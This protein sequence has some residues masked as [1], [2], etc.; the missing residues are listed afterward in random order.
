MILVADALALIVWAACDSLP[1][2]DKL[3][4]DVW[5]PDAV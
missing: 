2:L 1:L 3:F 5:V 4:G